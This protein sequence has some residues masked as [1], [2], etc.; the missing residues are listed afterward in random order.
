MKTILLLQDTTP[1]SSRAAELA[2]AIAGHTGAS[3]LLA[4]VH[5]ADHR[6]VMNGHVLSSAGEET[7][8]D[9]G[10]T[11]ELLHELA[12]INEKSNGYQPEIRL[13]PWPGITAQE[14]AVLVR[15]ENISLI[16]KGLV[17]KDLCAN[18]S[19]RSI[20]A[21]AGCPLLLVP[22]NYRMKDLERIV[23]VAD[24]RY[25]KPAVLRFL[26]AL[27]K[28]YHAELSVAHISAS[29][30]PHPVEA[31]ASALFDDGICPQL[32]YDRLDYHLIK[33]RD[34]RKAID[35]LIHGMQ[36]DLLVLENHQFHFE[37]L[38]GGHPPIQQWPDL[39]V[40]LLIFPG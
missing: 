9:G 18:L 6:S 16:V 3:L 32:Q 13:L 34:V 39:G 7:D 33:E 11:G 1:A 15:E 36:T 22:E 19:L 25:C 24:L 38:F 17:E 12:L 23:Y 21:R 28:G 8:T 20:L 14:L 37:E 10:D 29:G 35:V 26:T 31:F 27:A 40:P 2:F 30:L 5:G 4:N